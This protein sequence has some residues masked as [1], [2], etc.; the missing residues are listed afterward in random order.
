MAENKQPTVEELQAQLA[1]ANKRAA[2][3]EKAVDKAAKTGVISPIVKGTFTVT[4][5]DANG[6]PAQGK[7]KFKNGRIRTPLP[8]NGMEVPS[9]ALIQLANGTAMDKIEGIDNYPWFRELTKED[10][11]AVLDRLVNINAST[12]EPAK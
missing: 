8:S 11:Q 2:A 4:G 9:A 12:I 1:A 3:A 6:K 7:F 5:T 10:A